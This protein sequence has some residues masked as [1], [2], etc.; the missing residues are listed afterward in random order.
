MCAP[1]IS[2]LLRGMNEFIQDEVFEE[3]VEEGIEYFVAFG[4]A[5]LLLWVVAKP[6]IKHRKIQEK[7]R[8]GPRQWGEEV[9]WSLV[10]MIGATMLGLS[11]LWT[12]TVSPIIDLSRNSWLVG[13][14]GFFV[15]L[16]VNDTWFYWLHRWLHTNKWA[17]RKVHWIHHGSRDVTPLAGQRFHPVELFLI[18]VPSAFLPILF[19]LS[20]PWYFA[21]FL[22]SV[23]NNIY[24]HGGFELLPTSWEKI[25]I[26]RH[27]TTSLHHNMHHDRVRGNYALYFTWWDKVMGTEFDDYAEVRSA[28]NDRIKGRVPT[29]PPRAQSLNEAH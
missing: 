18:P 26:L 27:K 28:L 1:T 14:L 8:A 19:Q 15:M 22:F 25:P 6:F 20:D 24:A 9:L 7:Q 16:V 21:S 29:D 17:F 3:L 5:F 13:A 12:E 10:A 11:L 23:L 4:T 2:F